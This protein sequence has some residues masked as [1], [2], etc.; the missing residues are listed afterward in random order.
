MTKLTSEQQARDEAQRV[1]LL[2]VAD[3]QA[4]VALYRGLAADPLATPACKRFNKAR[5]AALQKHLRRLNH[6]R[7]TS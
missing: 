6:T 5:A 4:V 1:A 2:P 3:Q 7:K